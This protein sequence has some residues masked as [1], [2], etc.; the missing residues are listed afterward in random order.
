MPVDPDRV[1][2]L[3]GIAVELSQSSDRQAFLARECHGDPELRRRLDDLLAAVLEGKATPRN[4]PERIGLAYRA[5]ANAFSASSAH[6][7]GEALA[8][9]PKLGDD[10]QA[11]HR[12][13]AA[14]AAALAGSG[15]GK[16]HPPPDDAAK[17]KLRRQSLDWLQAELV[18]WTKIFDSDPAA[19][20]AK[21]SPTL[22]HWKADTD[23]AGIRDEKE[24]ARMPD[25]ERAVFY[26]LWN[27][28]DKLLIRAAGGE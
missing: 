10:R 24:L 13:N 17:A 26:Q 4:D 18:A 28:V 12:C 2:R 14:C 11:Q 9:D 5:H 27:D 16:D 7:F 3:F 6:L 15:Q 21:I 23:L 19:V 1:K 20:K 25:K 8:N 22:K